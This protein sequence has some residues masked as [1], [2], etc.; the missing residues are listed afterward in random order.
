MILYRGWGF[1]V[2][3]IPCVCVLAGLALSGKGSD[4]AGWITLISFFV[5][6]LVVFTV[7]MILNRKPPRPVADPTT[8]ITRMVGKAHDMYNINM[9]YWGIVIV[10]VAL[11]ILAYR[12]L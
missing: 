7:G 3:I 12:V 8:G 9:E 2:L 5:S 6:G 1:L 11:G 10:T 4:P